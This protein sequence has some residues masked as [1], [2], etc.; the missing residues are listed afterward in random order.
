MIIY[1][2]Y[3]YAYIS[4]YIRI[5]IYI[6]IQCGISDISMQIPLLRSILSLKVA[7]T[8]VNTMPKDGSGVRLAEMGCDSKIYQLGIWD[9][10]VRTHGIY[11]DVA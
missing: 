4:I 6:H 5:Y 11:N 7:I 3:V 1:I 9:K 10:H 2:L 8:A